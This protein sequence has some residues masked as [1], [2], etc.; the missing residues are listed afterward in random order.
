MLD[1]LAAGAKRVRVVFASSIAVFGNP[2]PAQGVDDHT[3]LSPELHYGGHKA[4]METAI[5]MYSNRGSIDGISLRLPGILARPRTQSGMKSGFISDIFHALK[6]G[7]SFTC[8]TRPEARTWVQ[9][10]KQ[11][12]D[13]LAHAL[14]ADASHFPRSRAITLPATHLAMG[15]LVSEIADQCGTDRELI[16]WE[17]D[18]DLEA[19]F[20]AFPPLSADNAINAGFAD[21]GS[22]AILV[23]SAL[24]TL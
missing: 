9:S 21:D 13:N 22:A 17:P 24:E 6:A 23:K 5:A 16:S 7:E 4:M 11:V 12:C 2:L 8:P 1:A 19:A 18:S 20:A 3:P 14:V 15:E 10:V